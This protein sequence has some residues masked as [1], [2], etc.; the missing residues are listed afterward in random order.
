M[1]STAGAEP[2]DARKINVQVAVRCRPLNGREKEAGFL[3]IVNTDT[4]HNRVIVA[5]KKVRSAQNLLPRLRVCCI[6]QRI[7]AVAVCL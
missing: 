5:H 1:A 7:P 2:E 4:E 3:H 6:S